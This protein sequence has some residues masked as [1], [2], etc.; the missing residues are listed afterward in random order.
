MD[1]ARSR[2]LNH[3]LWDRFLVAYKKYASMPRDE[4][5]PESD[6]ISFFLA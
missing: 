1:Y 4:V 2:G 3:M 6:Q 5:N